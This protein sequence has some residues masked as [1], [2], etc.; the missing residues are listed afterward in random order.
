MSAPEQELS[1]L[2]ELI[3]QCQSIASTNQR[4]TTFKKYATPIKALIAQIYDP[5]QK[6]HVTRKNIEK[7]EKSAANKAKS[8]A[9]PASLSE[10]LTELSGGNLT[11]HAALHACTA[12]LSRYPRFREAVLRALNKDLQIRVG[13][14]LV[15]QAFPL[16]VP[17]F[18][19]ALSHPLENHEAFYQKNE[20]NFFLSRKLD[21]CRC[22]FVCED[23]KA[24]AYSRSG[25]VFPAH[26]EG[27]AYFL[28]QFKHL[29]GVIDGEMGVVDSDNK[30]YFNLS[31]SL[32][33]PNAAES[34]KNR[35][36]LTLG[37]DQRMTYFAFDFI[38]LETFKR[39][40]G[41]PLFLER[42]GM[43]AQHLKPLMDSDDQKRVCILEQVPS[44]RMNTLWS[45]AENK[46][47]EGLILRM[48]VNYEGK[49]SRFMLK[50]KRAS[51]DEFMIEDA[52]ATLQ[53]PP[54]GTE[55]ELALEHVGITYKNNRVWVGSGFSW[56]ERK[57]Y[58]NNPKALIGRYITVCYNGESTD[59]AGDFSLRHPRVKAMYE[60]SGRSH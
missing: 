50:R 51:D 32:M 5:F 58:A 20:K 11:G 2:Q 40:G 23:G 4:C 27:L 48:N 13:V 59:K 38:P 1:A 25:H 14:Q 34:S 7:F 52:T 3:D 46:G 33:N 35:K 45:E 22:I 60:K 21:G 6:F 54:N 57:Q 41:P 9:P 49:K 55:Q 29:T 8:V 36:N 56:E 30:E 43:L 18:S 42:Q 37:P 26:I 39:G 19:C 24:T 17:V 10:L 47:W 44:S 31:N 16:L 28:D 53:M 12:F 15:N